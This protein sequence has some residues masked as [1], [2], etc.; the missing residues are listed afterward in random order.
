[1][2]LFANLGRSSFVLVTIVCLLLTVGCSQK[3]SEEYL[4]AAQQ[5][6]A[7][8]KPEAAIVELKNA[9][10][11]DPQAS[12]PRF[13]LGKLY[14]QLGDYSGAEKELQ[15]ALELGHPAAQVVPQLS[16]AHQRAG[17]FNAL[18]DVDHQMAELTS[19]EQVEIGFFKIQSMLELDQLDEAKA[20]IEEL[21]ALQT[22]SIY[23]DLVAVISTVLQDDL[24]TATE[25]AKEARD[26]SPLN[27]DALIMLGRLYLQ[28]QQ[29]DLA[30]EA[31][32]DYLSKYPKDSNTKFMLAAMLVELG[33][34]EE[35]D[36]YVDDLLKISKDNPMLNQLKGIILTEQGKYEAAYRRLSRA[37]DAGR[38]DPILRLVAGFAAFQQG[39]YEAA[40]LHLSLIASSLPDNHPGIKLLAASQLQLGLADDATASLQR[41]QT[42]DSSDAGLFSRAGYE[43]VKA[44][45]L[46]DAQEMLQRTQQLGDGA[47]D[48]LRMGLLQL[49]LNQIEGIIN[50]EQ[51]VAQAPDSATAQSTLATAYLSTNQ[52]DKAAALASD[53]KAAAPDA[54][55]PYVLAAE[56]AVRNQDIETARSEFQQA[57]ALAPEE[58]SVLLAY[59]RFLAQQ[60]DLAEA[61]AQIDRVL[62]TQ[63]NDQAALALQY[64]VE[65]ERGDTATALRNAQAQLSANPNNDELRVLVARMYA[66]EGQFDTALT[67]LE[68]INPDRQTPRDFWRLKGQA[69]IQGG[70]INAAE[71]HYEQWL[72]LFPYDK[73]AALGRLLLLDLSG[74]FERGVEVTQTFLSKRPD[75]QVVVLQA[76]FY[77]LIGDVE[78]SR[79]SLSQLAETAANNPFVKAIIARNFLS[80]G[81]Y[82]QAIEPAMGAYT[83]KP[84]LRNL[85]VAV[86]AHDGI[87]DRDTALTLLKDYVAQNPNDSRARML[88]A[89]RKIAEDSS[90][91]IQEY[92]KLIEQNENNFVAL[93]N[94]AY[95]LLQEGDDESAETYALRAVE[96]QPRNPAAADTL[97]QIYRAQ[98][99]LDEALELYDLTV[100]AQ[101]QNEEVYLNYIEVLLELGNTTVAERRLK[102]R[103]FELPASQQRVA[104]LQAKYNL[105][106]A[107]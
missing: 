23:Q 44:G 55:Q 10:Q 81:E 57:L 75:A 3:T 13:E 87:D 61:K 65:R 7:E 46:A 6:I 71:S 16:R 38:N 31:Y 26:K 25:L 70:Q 84:G 90:A 67:T 28:Q 45:N 103:T 4:A 48:L 22:S 69:L 78:S 27:Q 79:A 41:L 33:R 106:L 99:R 50:L 74:D 66:S 2:S 19:A 83:E 91:A 17:S 29:T 9:I 97:A 34:T 96:L 94:I 36:R 21:L 86:L 5:L 42:E 85:L 62:S 49:S 43:L 40:N 35:A 92:A 24:A 76:H 77:S 59:A 80:E 47:E 105:N 58:P 93:N 60:G 39:D 54:P 32:S 30:I 8:D 73:D 11:Q 88:L 51:A 64:L 89:E 53:W 20:L 56:I 104:D 98:N 18:V 1:M 72:D 82:A 102:D 101:M 63:P 14:L 12:A 52:I 68:R 37:I 100:D 107:L 95:L 15:R